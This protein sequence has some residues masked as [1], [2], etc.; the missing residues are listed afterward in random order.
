MLTSGQW[1]CGEAAYA[2]PQ[3]RTRLAVL[4]SSAFVAACGS[5]TPA[6]STASSAPAHVDKWSDERDLGLEGYQP[7]LWVEADH[8]WIASKQEIAVYARG[9]AKT[10]RFAGK[11]ER[12]N[13]ICES[14]GH[15]YAVGIDGSAT[16]VLL[17]GQAKGGDFTR[18]AFKPQAL[19]GAWCGAHY[20]YA[21]GWSGGIYRALTDGDDW[22]VDWSAARPGSI[23][24]FNAIHGS[25]DDD[26]FVVG[27]GGVVVHGDGKTWEEQKSGVDKT[28]KAV[29]SP[30]KGEAWAAGDDA[31]VIHTTDGGKT[32]SKVA[33]GQSGELRA[34]IAQG[35][36]VLL[37][38]RDGNILASEDGGAHFARE[39]RIP[40]GGITAFARR[41][42]GTLL[43]INEHRLLARA[44]K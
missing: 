43:A 9:G 13:G 22:A 40:G 44:A 39:Q 23:G 2:C 3:M 10:V 28:L 34:V 31:T 26:I 33:G 4:A 42:N 25:A 17:H 37:G 36:L 11:K 15:V 41:P 8:E 19:M 35:S 21:V 27:D 18:V 20:A 38:D 24:S 5:T 16:G 7:K 29:F 30:A 12:F 1:N 32:W 6:P 14:N